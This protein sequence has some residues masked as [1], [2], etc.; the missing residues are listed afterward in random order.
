VRVETAFIE[1]PPRASDL[2]FG[3][4]LL[5]RLMLVCE[6]VGIRRFFVL[7]ADSERDALRAS[8]GTFRDRPQVSF[9]S[10]LA[11]L[12][13][14]MPHT[15][16]CVAIRGNLA[17][18][19]SQLRSVLA[20]QAAHCG[21]VVELRLGKA[22]AGGIAV[23]P[24]D[25]LIKANASG[26]VQIGPIG[27]LPCALD[28][29]PDDVRTAELRLARHLRSESYA[30]DAPLARLL[31]RR[32]SWRISYLLAHT[33]VTP[34]QVTIA[35][36]VLGMLSAWL[37][38]QPRYWPRL[39][40]AVLL[41]VSTTIDG[42]DG[43][44]ARLKLQE[45]RLG[46]RLDTLTDNLVHL[47]LFIGL[48]TGCYRA[49]NSRAYLALLAILVG[50][51]VACVVA[52]HRAR[53]AGRGD[54]DWFEKLERLTGRDFAYL[55]LMLAI[56]NRIHFFAWGA[57]FGTYVFA[58]VLWSCAQRRAS[59]LVDCFDESFVAPEQAENIGLLAEL[60]ELR[61]RRAD[62]VS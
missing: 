37:F 13:D 36:T 12:L 21:E 46:A 4:P 5:E 26:S 43:E 40:A 59:S 3:R 6:R 35:S 55:L 10:S 57:A 39:V 58:A 17:I 41:L 1:S 54:R 16:L 23:G 49:S 34:N 24:L 20:S 48:M 62:R 53:R 9:V 61:R 44:L 28:G 32:L 8:M 45:S 27:H 51:F 15:A 38:A 19:P 31:D 22:P 60:R 42:V 18:A 56:V 50:G 52:G 25:R 2:I 11:Q 14:A 29:L 33:A 30:K 47:A 7:A